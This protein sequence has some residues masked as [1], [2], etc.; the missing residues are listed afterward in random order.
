MQVKTKVKIEEKGEEGV[1]EKGQVEKDNERM[2]KMRNW[3]VR[4]ENGR[5]RGMCR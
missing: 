3:E 4:E 5:F 1:K 2:K